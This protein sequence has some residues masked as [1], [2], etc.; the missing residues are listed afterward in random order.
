M[1][2]I[3]AIT[4]KLFHAKHRNFRKNSKRTELKSLQIA[5][6]TQKFVQQF[7]RLNTTFTED[8]IQ[9]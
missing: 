4:T 2:E 9:R 5:V 7:A 6:Q 3:N 8:D 1:E